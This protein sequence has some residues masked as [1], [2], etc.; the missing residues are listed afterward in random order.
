MV[1][2]ARRHT[3]RLSRRVY[4]RPVAVAMQSGD[5]IRIRGN[6]PAVEQPAKAGPG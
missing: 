1:R 2:I 5:E 4:V 6:D 3:R